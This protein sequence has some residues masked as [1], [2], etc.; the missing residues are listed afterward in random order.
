M[1]SS[2]KLTL[3]SLLP[4]M[5]VGVAQHT[6]EAVLQSDVLNNTS[7]CQARQQ[8]VQLRSEVSPEVPQYSDVC[9]GHSSTLSTRP[10]FYK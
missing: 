1:V 7:P 6:C 8:L 3:S 2:T 5:V 4:V 10:T 9:A